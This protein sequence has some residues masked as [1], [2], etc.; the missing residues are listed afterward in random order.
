[1]L[2]ELHGILD[3]ELEVGMGSR[4]AG[5]GREILDEVHQVGF[6]GGVVRGAGSTGWPELVGI[7]E[8]R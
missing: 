4:F 5:V 6:G 2:R 8:P 3:E 1:M 7:H